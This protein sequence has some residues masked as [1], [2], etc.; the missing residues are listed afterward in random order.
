MLLLQCHCLLQRQ[1]KPLVEVVKVPC[2]EKLRF[3][4]AESS[5]KS[6]VRGTGNKSKQ[7]SFN[8][9]PSAYV[10]R[11]R[12]KFPF[13]PQGNQDIKQFNQLIKHMPGYAGNQV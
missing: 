12:K 7:L 8:C 11:A 9:E 13:Y 4:L 2:S 5:I 3:K 10:S 6:D 1:L